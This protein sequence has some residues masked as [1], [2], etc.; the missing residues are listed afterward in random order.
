MVDEHYYEKPEW[1]LSHGQRYD[2]YDRARSKVYVGEYASW[3]NTLYNATGRRRIHDLPRT[4][5]RRRPHGLL[6]PPPRQHTPY[7]L[8][9]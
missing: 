2:K 9:P 1:F 3:G 8:E 6:R 4:Q 7:L 5:R